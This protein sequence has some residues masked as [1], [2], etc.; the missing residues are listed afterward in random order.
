MKKIISLTFAV[1]IISFVAVAHAEVKAGSVSFTPFVGGYFFERNQNVKDA[2]IFGLRGGYNFTD[3]FAME[4]MVS[5][6]QTKNENAGDS[7]QNV[8][9]CSMEGLY[10]FMPHS[11]FVP[12]VALG[13]GG[14]HYGYEEPYR[15]SRLAVDYGAG[16]K[17]FITKD[18]AVRADVRHVIPLND[19]YNDL[20]CTL[21][22]NFAFGRH[23]TY[24]DENEIRN[25]IKTEKE[26]SYAQAEES[27]DAD[28]DGISDDVD[29][30]PG[31]PMGTVVD[32]EGC[33]VVDLKK[34][35]LPA[36]S[37][38]D[39]IPDDAD[40]CPGTPASVVVDKNGC[41][42]DSDGDGVPD[43][44]DKCP[45]TPSGV[46]VD[47][48]GC[49]PDSDADGIPDSLDKC[50]DTPAGVKV[51]KDGCTI[52]E[53]VV[54]PKKEVSQVVTIETVAQFEAGQTAVNKKYYKEIKKVAEYLKEHPETIAWIA[55][56]TDSVEKKDNKVKNKKLSMERGESVRKLLITRFGIDKSRLT[57]V[58]FGS[59]KPLAG[60]DT[61]EGR[62]K[63]R[64]VQVFIEEAK[65]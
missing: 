43:Y 21:G 12:F 22:I 25:E 41:P 6:L 52:V 30:C 47:K 56:H 55:G 11:R 57:A 19:R 46:T 64:R 38:K 16:M 39:G 49:S 28:R 26:K 1:L 62:K 20:M 27:L 7:A 32:K 23:N 51:D 17:F 33:P 36:D 44:L 40:K 53:K 13:V 31:T 48:N 14:I 37:D 59:R 4:G 42:P 58:G 65:K 45:N 15:V 10:H 3:N 5:F 63:N 61:K 9:S 35:T 54:E 2:A 18:I 29:K 24:T 50:Q 60:N 34:E 8:Y